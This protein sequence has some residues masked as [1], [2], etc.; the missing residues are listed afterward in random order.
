MLVINGYL[1]FLGNGSLIGGKALTSFFYY[2]SEIKKWEDL[3]RIFGGQLLRLKYQAKCTKKINNTKQ[4][5]LSNVNVLIWIFFYKLYFN[6]YFSFKLIHEFS[7]S[8]NPS[9]NL[10]INFIWCYKISV[11]SKRSQ[12]RCLINCFLTLMVDSYLETTKMEHVY[13]TIAIFFCFFWQKQ[14]D[15]HS[16]KSI[17]YIRYKHR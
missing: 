14:N 12:T 4:K 13:G 17:E 8:F 15:V 5:D 9:F 16:F 10:I 1:F 11:S 7:L 2:L 3:H 6:G